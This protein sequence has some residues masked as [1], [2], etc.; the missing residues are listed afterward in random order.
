MAD[1]LV[2]KNV[3]VASGTILPLPFSYDGTNY[4]P[5]VRK[6]LTDLPVGLLV[7]RFISATGLNA[8]EVKGT[9]GVIYMIDVF[10]VTDT[11]PMFLKLYDA[12]GAPVPGTTTIKTVVPIV[13]GGT[14][15]VGRTVVFDGGLPFATGISRALMSDITDAAST[16]NATASRNAVAIYYK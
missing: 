2:Y 3:E 14:P 11:A 6:H 8:A 16:G 7:H 4:S 15:G 12:I 13:G 9:P 5:M 1:T 10:N